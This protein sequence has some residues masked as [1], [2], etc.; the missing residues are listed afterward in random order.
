MRMNSETLI[1]RQQTANK[2]YEL[3]GRHSDDLNV[4]YAKYKGDLIPVSGLPLQEFYMRVRSIPFQIDNKPVEL[5]LRPC[6]CFALANAG[7]GLDCKKKAVLMASW[8]NENMGRKHFR[9]VATSNRPDR[10]ITHTYPEIKINGE[11]LPL[12]ATYQTNKIFIKNGITKKVI[13]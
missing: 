11:W 6:Y 3:V 10:R 13:L 12:D 1:D 9:F 8:I 7:R 2:M 4:V 5:L